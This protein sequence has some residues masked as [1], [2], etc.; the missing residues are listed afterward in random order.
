M[1]APYVNGATVKNHVGQEVRLV[2]AVAEVG[3]EQVTV[4]AADNLRVVVRTAQ[5][6]AYAGVATV[7][8]RGTVQPDF[9]VQET[10]V[11]DVGG[12]VP[13]DLPMFNKAIELYSGKHAAIFHG[14]A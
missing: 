11:K 12:A 14:S 2:G 1:P 10:A 8:V 6:S 3:G 9:S 7:E 5:P 13:V 4:S